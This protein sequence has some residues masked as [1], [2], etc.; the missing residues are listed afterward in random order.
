MQQTAWVSSDQPHEA[1]PAG[2][3]GAMRRSRA[4]TKKH[5]FLYVFLRAAK[6]ILKKAP[7][8]VNTEGMRPCLSKPSYGA[9]QWALMVRLMQKKRENGPNRPGYRYFR[10]PS[11]LGHLGRR[12]GQNRP[13][14][15]FGHPF[16]RQ[17]GPSERKFQLESG[18]DHR[19][20]AKS[21]VCCI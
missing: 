18:F 8:F 12:F 13:F 20:E 15:H 11:H 16:P 1:A 14:C 21:A 19:D 9:S 3:G 5:A 7:F 6:K 17:D 2:F 10:K 4:I